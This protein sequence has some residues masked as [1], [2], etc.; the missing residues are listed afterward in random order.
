MTNVFVS[1]QRIDSSNAQALIDEL[2]EAGFGVDHSPRNPLDGEDVRWSG[3]YDH[4][5]QQ[6]IDRADAFVIVVDP[7]WDSSTWMGEESQAATLAGLPMSY[8][9]PEGIAFSDGAMRSYL[10][11]RLPGEPA[12]AAL[13]LRELL[14]R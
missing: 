10:K 2:R 9:N 14:A 4:G 7:A 13:T 12:D 5:L 11:Q 8:W 3:W 1:S 6:A